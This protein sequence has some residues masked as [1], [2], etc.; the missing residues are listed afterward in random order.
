[1]DDIQRPP[2]RRWDVVEELHTSAQAVLHRYRGLW[3]QGG[4]RGLMMNKGAR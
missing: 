4:Y 3:I 2:L 1:V